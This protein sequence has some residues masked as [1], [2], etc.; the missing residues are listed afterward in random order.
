MTLEVRHC[1]HALVLAEHRSFQRAARAL[2][3]SQPALSRSVQTLE[4]STGV[5]LFD[6]TRDGVD[7][8]DA[9]RVF[10]ARAGALVSSAV[11]LER[12]M[13][14]MAGLEA[15][16][17]R[18]GAGV[19]PSEM[20]VVAAAAEMH[21][22]HPGIKLVLVTNSIDTLL[23]MCKRHEV[24]LVVGDVNTTSGDR[25]LVVE[26]LGWHKGHVAVRPGHP[27][28]EL[29]RPSLRDV[30]RH[31][32][33]FATRIPADFLAELYR[34]LDDG[35]D[36]RG[37]RRPLPAIGCDSPTMLKALVA[38][39]DAVTFLPGALLVD[40]LASGALATIPLEAPWLGRTFGIIQVAGRTPSPAA[41]AFMRLLRETD[42]AARARGQRAGRS[43]AVF[44]KAP[45]SGPVVRAVRHR[46]DRRAA[47]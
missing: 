9:G 18:V 41:G 3:I 32:L 2:G 16:E 8:T 35:E 19:Y 30:L 23:R 13:H 25:E 26:P 36:A 10:L 22:L 37:S 24:D 45:S 21:R 6:R 14:L 15:G 1:R 43:P 12:E 38:A 29:A 27:L 28:T 4:E 46:R 20:F 44:A 31:P 39:T 40:D 47:G 7:P 33:A 17:L 11:E 42:D 34:G 5:R